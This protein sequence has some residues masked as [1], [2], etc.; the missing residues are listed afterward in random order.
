MGLNS[1]PSYEYE[2]VINTPS[3]MTLEEGNAPAT[4]SEEIEL[5]R[6]KI[7]KSEERKRMAM[8][9]LYIWGM[10]ATIGGVIMGCIYIS[11]RF[12]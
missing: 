11:A 4:R 10:T 2:P 7:E 6:F 9:Q 12:G 1:P 5:K 3:E 8:Q